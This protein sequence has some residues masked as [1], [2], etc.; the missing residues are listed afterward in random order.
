MISEFEKK[1]RAK[2]FAYAKASI[3]LEGGLVSEELERQIQKHIQGEIEISDLR[4]YMNSRILKK[5]P[6]ERNSAD[7]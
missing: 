1:R 2:N 4:Q 5:Q 7:V 6:D 3:T